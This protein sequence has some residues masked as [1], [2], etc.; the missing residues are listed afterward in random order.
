MQR[1]TDSD[2]E[3]GCEN[4]EHECGEHSRPHP[5]PHSPPQ[6]TKTS[7]SD[8]PNLRH[9]VSPTPHSHLRSRPNGLSNGDVPCVP[10]SRSHT[11]SVSIATF[12]SPPPA[13]VS[14]TIPQ[15]HTVPLLA[16]KLDSRRK[17]NRRA[18]SL[19]IHDAAHLSL[20]GAQDSPM[21]PS[22][23]FGVDE[24]FA[25]HQHT[26]LHNHTPNLHDHSHVHGHSHEG[27]SHNM[28]GLF[29]HVMA[30][31]SSPSQFLLLADRGLVGWGRGY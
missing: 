18:P 11:R 16:P 17:H 28:R 29:L 5:H 21:T 22:Y 12:P 25:S 20:E 31:S 9:E 7:H 30:V 19:Q 13:P 23:R 24:H 2:H 8:V 4:H 15:S 14:S 3:G 27:H 26:H 10:S 1:P 6:C